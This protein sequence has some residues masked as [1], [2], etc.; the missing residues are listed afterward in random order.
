M[1]ED[2]KEQ[3]MFSRKYMWLPEVGRRMRAEYGNKKKEID[4]QKALAQ[5]D[6]DNRPKTNEC[7]SPV[8]N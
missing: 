4:K 8:C 5:T 6:C 7:D 2:T 3:Y 1:H